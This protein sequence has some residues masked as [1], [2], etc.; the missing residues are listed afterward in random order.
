MYIGGIHIIKLSLFYYFIISFLLILLWGGVCLSQEPRKVDGKLFFFPHIWLVC[1]KA[2]LVGSSSILPAQT[3]QKEPDPSKRPSVPCSLVWTSLRN[4]Q[5]WQ[6]DCTKSNL[7]WLC[8]RGTKKALQSSCTMC[9]FLGSPHEEC[10]FRK[11]G[12]PGICAF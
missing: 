3:K 4:P 10:W 12:V 8:S 2:W 7:V 11:S 5:Q 9:K 1:F 6:F